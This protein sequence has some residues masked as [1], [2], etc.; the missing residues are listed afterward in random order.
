MQNNRYRY[1]LLLM[2]LIGIV[3][4]F[5]LAF[6]IRYETGLF[7]EGIYHEPFEFYVYGIVMSIGVWILLYFSLDLDRIQGPQD[8]TIAGSNFVT[9]II[10]FFATVLAGAFLAKT[11]YSR[12]LL[13]FFFGLIV[14]VLLGTRLT[15]RA[16]LKNLKD[17][18]IGMRRVVIVG[19]S[20]LARELGER[21]HKHQEL[22]YDL[23]GFLYPAKVRSNGE[24][25]NGAAW[26]SKDLAGEL[27]RRNIQEVIFTVPIR[28]DTE[29]LEFIASCQKEKIQVKLIPEY[30]ELHQH[31]IRSLDIDGIPLFELRET[32]MAPVFEVFKTAMD[33]LLGS[34]LFLVF[35]PVMAVVG[36]LLYIASGGRV[37]EREERIGRGGR[38]FLMY[39][40]DIRPLAPSP[41]G[42]E[43]TWRNRL[44]RFLHRYSFSELPQ[45]WNVLKGDMSIVGPRPETGDRVRHYSAWHQRRLQFKPGMTGLAQVK[46]LRGFDSTDLKTKYDLEYAANYTPLLDITLILA[47]LGTLFMRRKGL[48]I[49][50]EMNAEKVTG[51][52]LR[53]KSV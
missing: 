53:P 6:F 1:L 13:V 19:R 41:A 21:I 32:S 10:I 20:E 28:R 45:L 16:W 9:A 47:T 8:I 44:G 51:G 43:F 15:M 4:S 30:Y 37:I 33:L 7:G 34:V 12:L 24:T 26:G 49:E 14:L 50:F 27:R 25:P 36:L 17:R 35:L 18:G 2:D 46:G 5:R 3:A 40:F 22:Q 31:Q 39:R 42:G 48:H 11:F 23:V 52:A 38:P 29:I